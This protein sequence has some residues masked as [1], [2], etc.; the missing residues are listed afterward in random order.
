MASAVPEWMTEAG[1][2]PAIGSV[3]NRE[4]V[5]SAVTNV[6]AIFHLAGKVSRESKDSREMYDISWYDLLA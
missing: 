3:T 5:A 6:S 1:V 2:Q 4:D